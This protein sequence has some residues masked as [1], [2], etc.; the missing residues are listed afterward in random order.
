LL[1]PCREPAVPLT[2]ELKKK[3]NTLKTLR[4]YSPINVGWL[5]LG[6]EKWQ[7]CGF[8]AKAQWA[9]VI[10]KMNKEGMQ[11]YFKKKYAVKK[12]PSW[13]RKKRNRVRSAW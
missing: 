12:S 11:E 8:E 3:H 4:R 13:I 1:P 7:Q 9:A 10:D 6:E 2:G 5:D